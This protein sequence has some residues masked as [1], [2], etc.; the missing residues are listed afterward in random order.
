MKTKIDYS[1]YLVTDSELMSTDT[2]EESVELAIKGGVT[3]VQ[4]REKNS[5]SRT[6]YE[7]ALR[8]RKIT[9]KYHIPLIINDR[10]DIALAVKADGIHVGQE[11]LP[12]DIIRKIVGP[13]MII[14]VSAGN[15]TDARKALEDGADYLGV[16]AMYAT[17][18]KTDADVTTL[19]ELALIRQE[20]PLPI[21]VI[22]G[23]NEH[24]IQTFFGTGINGAAV[25][26]AI[27]AKK[28]VT[29]AAKE[30]KQ[31]IRD[32]RDSIRF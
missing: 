5:D 11:D 10:L 22:G 25:V 32:P 23:I 14:G 27:V 8:V 30:L 16:G 21:V 2:V 1:L 13:D 31:L 18:T 26:S 28:D 6:F 7:M 3:L 4:L 15:L 24:T 17:N 9:D 29:A 12:A 19:D 20:I